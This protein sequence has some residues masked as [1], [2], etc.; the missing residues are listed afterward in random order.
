MASEKVLFKVQIMA[1][2]EP[3][4]LERIETKLLNL[5]KKE[6]VVSFHIRK[7]YQ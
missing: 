1:A 5:T 4:E 7:Y 6:E 2:G 3:E